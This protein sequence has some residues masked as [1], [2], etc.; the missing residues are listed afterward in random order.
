[1]K[2]GIV[3]GTRPEIIK[4]APVI[5]EVDSR[6]LDRF[7]IHTNQHYDWEM[8]ARFF[9]E[10]ELPAPDLNLQ[11][12]SGNH[13]EQTA[14]MLTAI[15]AAV[16]EEGLTHVVVQGDTNSGLAG[17]L[18]AAKLLRRVAHVEAGL[19]SYDMRMPEELNRRLIDH[20]SSDLFPPT[21][22]A[23]EVLVRESVPGLIHDPS[24]N[25][26]VDAV[27]RYAPRSAVPI[28]EREPQILMTLHRPENVDREETLRSIIGA[29]EQVASEHGLDVI[30][31]AHPR[32]RERLER[33]GIELP[34]RIEFAP[35]KSF[36]E[37]LSLQAGARLVMTDS[38]GVQ[39]EACVLGSPCVVLRS[40]TDRPETIEVGASS[41]GGIEREGILAAAEE[42]LALERVDW[43]QPFGDGSSSRTIV[44][45][46]VATDPTEKLAA[47]V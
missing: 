3:L 19:R 20:I 4:L 1:M 35:L 2:V 39:E 15:E 30:F 25:T 10:M 36:R 7:L 47:S 38:G 8:D 27:L 32:T 18:A 45:A 5:Q 43:P 9:E 21:A 26:V 17:A 23:H 14:K 40:H 16:E 24:G 22:T 34:S 29:V 31:P 6:S 13:G 28:A 46:L 33:F 41:L 44:D 11:V 37:L 12:G 42:M